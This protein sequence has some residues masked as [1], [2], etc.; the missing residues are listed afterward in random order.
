MREGKAACPGMQHQE[1]SVWSEKSEA[2]SHRMWHF[3]EREKK[4]W[5][6]G[7]EFQAEGST[8]ARTQQSVRRMGSALVWMAPMAQVGRRWPAGLGHITEKWTVPLGLEMLPLG[9]RDMKGILF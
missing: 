6:G 4:R 2:A 8:K 9:T 5:G 7:A 3:Q 1:G